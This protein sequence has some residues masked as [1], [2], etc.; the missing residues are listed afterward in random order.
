MKGFMERDAADL[1]P[2]LIAHA[3]AQGRTYVL[4]M[5]QACLQGHVRLLFIAPG[6]GFPLS[7]LDRVKDP[8][9]LIVILGGDGLNAQGPDGFPR[10]V[11]LLRWASRI[12]LHG[13]GGEPGHYQLAVQGALATGRCLLVESR[14]DHLPAWVELRAKVAPNTQTLILKTPPGAPPHLGE[15]RPAEPGETV[16]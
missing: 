3:T 5:L 2:Q 13:T 11:R 6:Q 8:R 12:M 9:P 4:P 1:M 7:T 14:G 10:A 15:M 16:H